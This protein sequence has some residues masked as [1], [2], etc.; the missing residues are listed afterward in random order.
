MRMDENQKQLTPHELFEIVR[1]G[2]SDAFQAFG[3]LTE[4]ANGGNEEV[5]GLVS[6]LDKAI[7][8]GEIPRPTAETK[9]QK[10]NNFLQELVSL[11]PQKGMLPP[12]NF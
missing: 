7:A 10:T 6:L 5:R 1:A 2:G 3:I 4:T 8:K 9:T 12:D 11:S